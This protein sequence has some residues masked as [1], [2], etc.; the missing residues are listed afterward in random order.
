MKAPRPTR[1]QL[2]GPLVMVGAA[3]AVGLS[4]LILFAAAGAPPVA[5]MATLLSEPLSSGTGLSETLLRATP[6]ILCTLSVSVA[7][8]VGL[9]NLGGEGQLA[10]GAFAATGVALFAGSPPGPIGP[11]L[12]LGAGAM[13]GALWAAVPAL[14]RVRLG[15]SEIRSTLMLNYVPLAWVEQL[16]LD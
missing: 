3:V 6:L 5:A 4:G 15:P 9:W 13:A 12:A 16:G 2:S 10:M 8:R 7:L 14:L 1:P 11:L